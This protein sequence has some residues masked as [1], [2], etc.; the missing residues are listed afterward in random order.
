M[1]SHQNS[2]TVKG[3]GVQY[4]VLLAQLQSPAGPVSA[5]SD[6]RNCVYY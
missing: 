2:Q 6:A 4:S 5:Q 1:T 3:A